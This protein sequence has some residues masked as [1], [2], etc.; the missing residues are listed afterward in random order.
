MKNRYVAIAVF[1]MGMIVQNVFGE[2]LKLETPRGVV[3]DVISDVPDGK[4]PFP[5]VI[6]G[7]GANYPMALPALEQPARQLLERGVAVFRFNWAYYT[8][9]PQT[10]RSSTDLV[11]EVEDMTAV[12]NKARSDPRIAADKLF[13]G[14]K[15]LGSVVA[16][17]VLRL[18]KEL[19]GALLLTPLCSRVPDGST[20]PTPTGDARYPGA[21]SETRPLA[22]ILGEQD[23]Q[24]AAPLLYR[25]AASTGSASRVAVVA[26]DH[27][28]EIPGLTGNAA[29]EATV[30]NARLAGLFAADFIAEGARR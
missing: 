11:L 28:F 27:S 15:S 8:K 7:P 23:P 5:A 2:S 30:R 3:L 13:V 29:V 6:L 21:P 14:G 10:G 9:D 26:G 20:E 17:R 18:N 22:F 4:G 16:W 19:K 1:A 12:L 24:C 25:F